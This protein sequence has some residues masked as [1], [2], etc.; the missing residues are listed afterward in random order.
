MENTKQGNILS[1]IFNSIKN[2]WVRLGETDINE[3]IIGDL[4]AATAKE[5]KA[6][7]EIQAQV[8]EQR[9]FVQRAKVSEEKAKVAAKGR[10][11]TTVADQRI[12]GDA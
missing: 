6:I 5:L 8:H 7:E 10:S 9:G 11:R 4:D 2:V 3:G 12:L 1:R